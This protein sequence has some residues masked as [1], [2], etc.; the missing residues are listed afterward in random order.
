[1]LG[2]LGKDA[3]P[4]VD[5]MKELAG[6]AWTAQTRAEELPSGSDHPMLGNDSAPLAIE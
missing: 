3:K 4:L 5:R 6:I 1:M 2:K